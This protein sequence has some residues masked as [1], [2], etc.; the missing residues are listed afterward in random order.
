MKNILLFFLFL[1]CFQ[2][3]T[4]AQTIEVLQ[5]Q[6]DSICVI[7]TMKMKAIDLGKILVEKCAQ[8]PNQDSLIFG[9]TLIKIAF[10]MSRTGQYAQVEEY[11]RRAIAISPLNT[12]NHLY[13]LHFLGTFSLDASKYAFADSLF[14]VALVRSKQYLGDTSDMY[15][16]SLYYKGKSR[17]IQSDYPDA[18][19]Q[20][21][22]GI[23][24]WELVKKPENAI[25]A[26][27]YSDLGN[28]KLTFGQS[29]NAEKDLR[30]AIQISEKKNPN[31]FASYPQYTS[32]ARFLT[33]NGNAVEALTLVEKVAAQM[34][35]NAE[36][37]TDFYADLVHLKGLIYFELELIDEAIEQYQISLELF[38]KIKFTK[39]RMVV[40]T[41]M[42]LGNAYLS[43]NDLQKAH[44]VLTE[45]RDSVV[46]FGFQ[47]KVNTMN[48][49]LH[50][51][52][53]ASLSGDYKTANTYF[54][55]AK[56]IY[57][58][59]FETNDSL[60]QYRMAYITDLAMIN[61]RAGQYSETETNLAGLCKLIKEQ[62]LNNWSMR[63]MISIMATAQL[64]NQ[65]PAELFEN[66][67]ALKEMQTQSC[68]HELFAMNDGQRLSRIKEVQRQSDLMLT[69]LQKY[70]TAT[71]NAAALCLDYQLFSKSLLLSA[72]Q[73]IR[74]NIES[75][76]TLAPIFS[77][78]VTAHEQLAWSYMQSK[79][80]LESLQI[81]IGTLETR[82]DSLEKVLAQRSAAFATAD[83]RA[84]FTW[85]NTRDQLK[86]GEAAIEITRFHQFGT[87]E[88]TDTVMYA[89]FVITPEMQESP[90]VIFIKDAERM[91]GIVTE[92]YLSECA[93]RTGR[94]QTAELFDAFWA[95]IQPMLGAAKRVFVSSDGMFHKINLGAIKINDKQYLADQIEVRPVF[96]LREIAQKE[97]RVATTEK[98]AFLIGNPKFSMG[99][100]TMPNDVS[101]TRSATETEASRMATDY[102][103][104][105]GLKLDPLPGSQKEVEKITELLA[106]KGWKTE[107]RI[108]ENATKTAI[109]EL[110]QAQVIHLATHGYF[111]SSE[112]SGTAGLSRRNVE[113]N[114]M[115]RSMLFLAGAQNT[116][117]QKGNNEATKPTDDGILTA[118]EAQNLDL[119]NTELVVLSACK[120][121]QG[122]IQ[123]G[124]GVF[125]LQRALHIAGAQ[126]MILSLWDVD[127]SVAL[128]F[129]LSFYQKWL[130]G[131]EKA[132]AF[133]ATQLEIKKAHPLP[134]YWAGFIYIGN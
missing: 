45:W 58:A 116:L 130:A 47:K 29:K 73:K 38:R 60:N 15:F 61:M 11:A 7:P 101:V 64:A 72:A 21:E 122:K 127:D 87:I 79:S 12:E 42:D 112:R 20:F 83:L 39:S 50:S 126:S 34:R 97:Q 69:A 111:M 118:Y 93:D 107:T 123:N 88:P 10:L 59:N 114:P 43:K 53:C 63:K 119:K 77:D 131:A 75:D 78:W 36:Q 5:R 6:F 3:K 81:T 128:E 102:P 105:R 9:K 100:T 133:R 40:Q 17:Y 22:A 62:R 103:E 28:L 91:E 106:K 57:D 56:E 134:Y 132:A 65:K 24:Q 86:K 33:S 13:S 67:L 30:K 92:K 27:F 68:A 25:L 89:V 113:R 16:K 23:K 108:H 1:L 14:E 4:S 31:G 76:A 120:T 124:E 82:A 98:R 44:E 37:N 26:N 125:G 35:K 32:L 2:A 46:V 115:L 66:L 109:K 121:A 90:K 117:D 74:Q 49:M 41:G 84:P 8:N 19:R 51:G 18:Y 48:L 96:S 54:K 94:G 129:M 110:K 70:P 80:D 95:P 52:R 99:T 55:S 104:T 71:P 85:Q